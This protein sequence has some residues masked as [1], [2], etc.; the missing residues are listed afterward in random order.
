MIKTDKPLYKAIVIINLVFIFFCLFSNAAFLADDTGAERSFNFECIFNIVALLS[1]MHYIVSG[2]TKDAAK[3]YKVFAG[4]YALASVVSLLYMYLHAD[5]S[6]FHFAATAVVFGLIIIL[7]VAPNLGKARSLTLCGIVIALRLADLI[8]AF[9][10]VTESAWPLWMIYMS[11]FSQLVLA[12][13]LGIM[14]YA[15]YLDK[16]ARHSGDAA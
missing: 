10:T 14:N 8:L 5:A 16:A 9:F 6:L 15:K 13:L 4:L 2:Y 11:F 7:A 1:A 3:Y 12:V